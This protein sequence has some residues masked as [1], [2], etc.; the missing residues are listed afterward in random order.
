M[1]QIDFKGLLTQLGNGLTDLAKTNLK[2]YATAAEADGKQMLSTL[3]SDLQNW[4]TELANGSITASDLE[5]LVNSKKDI[6][7][8]SALQQAGLA[9][10]RLDQFKN[11]AIQLIVKTITSV[12][13]AL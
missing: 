9:A 3:E 5:W 1:P 8:M 12:L 13:K 6:I 7:V 2:D 10:I 11:D 4:T